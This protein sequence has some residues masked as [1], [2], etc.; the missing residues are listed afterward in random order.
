MRRC[1]A[2][3][4]RGAA[5]AEERG[6]AAPPRQPLHVGPR[7]RPPPELQRTGASPADA[8]RGG[9][10]CST[11]RCRWHA[12]V[13]RSLPRHPLALWPQCAFVLR[14]C[15]H[16]AWYGA[17][18]GVVGR[19]CGHKERHPLTT[20]PL[21]RCSGSP[22]RWPEKLRPA[23]RLPH[24]GTPVAS[25]SSRAAS[26]RC[27]GWGRRMTLE[28]LGTKNQVLYLKVPPVAEQILPSFPWMKLFGT[29]LYPKS[30]HLTLQMTKSANGVDCEDVF[31]ILSNFARFVYSN[32]EQREKMVAAESHKVHEHVKWI[33]EL[34]NKSFEAKQRSLVIDRA[35]HSGLV[36]QLGAFLFAPRRTYQPFQLIMFIYGPILCIG[37]PSAIGVWE[38]FDEQCMLPMSLPPIEEEEVIRTFV[39]TGQDLFLKHHV[40]LYPP[41]KCPVLTFFPAHDPRA[42]LALF[43]GSA[44]PIK[45]TNSSLNHCLNSKCMIYNEIDPNDP[46]DIPG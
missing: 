14:R 11:A 23:S 40:R 38:R 9:A 29:H 10:S 5:P 32:R 3:H 37:R 30:R 21:K 41:G 26:L 16:S 44:T 27:E 1:A 28:D 42:D 25:G 18:G 36:R 7:R 34:K 35:C 20:L 45:S 39:A 46:G 19:R 4:A 43:T 13:G 17:T 33:T 6:R 15:G 12:L 24:P 8:C 31:E 22:R 2:A